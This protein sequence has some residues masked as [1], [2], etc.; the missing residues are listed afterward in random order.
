MEKRFYWGL[1]L[2]AFFLAIGLLT[3][4]CVDRACVPISAQL[5]QA[6]EMALSGDLEQSVTLAQAAKAHWHSA[7]HRIAMVADHNPM[8]EIDSLF[9]QMQIHGQ[10]QDAV[11]FGGYC[12]RLSELVKA[13]ADAHRFNWWNLL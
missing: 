4:F 9:A 3:T 2:L 1:G 8:D 13:V 7:W 10:A 6:S 11:A 12:A 5:E